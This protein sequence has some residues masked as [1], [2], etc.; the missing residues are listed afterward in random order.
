MMALVR[1]GAELYRRS[2]ADQIAHSLKI[3][4]AIENSGNS[5]KAADEF[6]EKTTRPNRLWQ[7]DFTCLNV[8]G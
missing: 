8:I 4:S 1:R 2:L 5:T 3:G 6:H 7:T